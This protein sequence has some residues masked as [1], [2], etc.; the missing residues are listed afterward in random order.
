VG[1]CATWGPR[2]PTSGLSER[3]TDSRTT[4]SDR[5]LETPPTSS[6][7]LKVSRNVAARSVGTNAKK[8]AIL[9]PLKHR[10]PTL[11]IGGQSISGH[12]DVALVALTLLVLDSTN[13]GVTKL[14]SF[15]SERMVPFVAW[16]LFGGVIVDRFSGRLLLLISDSTR[17]CDR[18]A[19]GLHRL[20]P[21]AVLR[22]ARPRRAPWDL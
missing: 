10:E 22:T 16:V 14:A 20:W 18:S 6:R 9:H 1:W 3:P 4:R 19:R 7:V 15:A 8:R 17:D 21:P 11:L 12:V 5:P 13:H 2:R